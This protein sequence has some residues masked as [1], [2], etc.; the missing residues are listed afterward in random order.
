M[1]VLDSCCK[2]EYFLASNSRV[3]SSTVSCGGM[4]LYL[5]NN[6]GLLLCCKSGYLLS[7]F[8]PRTGMSCSF[9]WG[10]GSV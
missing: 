8:V 4:C 10:C 7:V 6:V 5:V 2:S 9:M 3:V 1:A